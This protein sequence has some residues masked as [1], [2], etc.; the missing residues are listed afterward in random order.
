MLPADHVVT[1]LHRP[2]IPELGPFALSDRIPADDEIAAL[3]QSLTKFLIVD[4]APGRMAGS[5]E[6]GGMHLCTIFWHV[7]KRGHV[8]A[9]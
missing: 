9:G 4:L 7:Y 5:H 6:Y 2:R 1:G 8:E 3:D